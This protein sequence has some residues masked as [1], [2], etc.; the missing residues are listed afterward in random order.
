MCVSIFVSQS[1]LKYNS[2]L[3][4]KNPS[5][6]QKVYSGRDGDGQLIVGRGG[7]AEDKLR[8]T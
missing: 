7:G 8:L 4:H 6:L 3:S 2:S 5:T 1:D